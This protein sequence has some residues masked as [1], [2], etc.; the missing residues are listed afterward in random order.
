MSDVNVTVFGPGVL[1]QLIDLNYLAHLNQEGVH[2]SKDPLSAYPDHCAPNKEYDHLSD[3]FS[4]STN[5]LMFYALTDE[6]SKD[7]AIKKLQEMNEYTNEHFDTHY[8]ERIDKYSTFYMEIK[9]HSVNKLYVDLAPHLLNFTNSNRSERTSVLDMFSDQ[10]IM[11]MIYGSLN[12]VMDCEDYAPL[13]IKVDGLTLRDSIEQLKDNKDQQDIAATSILLLLVYALHCRTLDEE[14]RIDHKKKIEMILEGIPLSPSCQTLVDRYETPFPGRRTDN[15]IDPAIDDFESE[16]IELLFKEVY[17]EYIYTECG[18]TLQNLTARVEHLTNRQEC[19]TILR[20][21]SERVEHL[22]AR[23]VCETTLQ[24]LS[25]RVEHLTSRE[26]CKTTL[27]E[28]PN[29]VEKNSQKNDGE[30]K[31]FSVAGNRS[32][33]NSEHKYPPEESHPIQSA[34]LRETQ[35]ALVSE[36]Q[37]SHN[38]NKQTE[39]VINEPTLELHEICACVQAPTCI[40]C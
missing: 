14:V 12:S 5:L 23:D 34:T 28:Q 29:R 6:P 10:N 39:P 40:V 20:Q 19:K 38:I 22:V 36:T 13:F 18:V 4:V 27:Q 33:F 15:L 1:C 21:L 26:K 7:K 17:Y 30:S 31:L 3:V 35:V 11:E 9:N 16:I 2:I 25:E 37:L 24:Q 32:I 8:K